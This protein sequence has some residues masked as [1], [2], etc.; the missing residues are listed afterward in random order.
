MAP[1]TGAWSQ[2]VVDRSLRSP[3]SSITPTA[4]PCRR[5]IYD[6]PEELDEAALRIYQND[7]TKAEERAELIRTA[8]P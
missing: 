4:L 1:Y 6:P 3:S 8:L 2:T 5:A 7:F